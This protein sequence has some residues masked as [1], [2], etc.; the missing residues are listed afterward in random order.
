MFGSA[1]FKRKTSLEKV[2]KAIKEHNNCT[3]MFFVE[4]LTTTESLVAAGVKMIEFSGGTPYYDVGVFTQQ[5]KN[6]TS[7]EERIINM[8]IMRRTL[9][10]DV[11]ITLPGYGTFTSHTPQPFSDNEA[12]ILSKAGAD[13]CHTHKWQWE[14]LKKLVE[15][16]HRNGLIVDAYISHSKDKHFYEGINADTPEEVAEATKKMEKIGV[17]M[18]GIMSGMSYLG[19]KGGKL[20][21]DVKDRITALVE[22]AS[23]PTLVEGGLTSVTSRNSKKPE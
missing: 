17:D 5:W 3:L 8:K 21:L 12:L 4:E 1:F 11:Y 2:Q 10:D 15:V 6:E 16:A 19:S 13:G 18:I 22:T 7:L 20:N 14:D 9:G 23:V